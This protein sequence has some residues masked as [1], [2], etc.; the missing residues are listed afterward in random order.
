MES[1]VAGELKYIIRADIDDFNEGLAKASKALDRM[2]QHMEESAAEGGSSLSKG[3]AQ[4]TDA[5]TNSIAKFVSNSTAQLQDF[6]KSAASVAGNLA[7]TFSGMATGTFTSWATQGIFDTKFL[8][9][10]QIQMQALTHSAEEGSRA[11]AMATNYFKNNP[12]NRFDVTDATKQLIQ[13]G[14]SLDEVPALLEKMGNVSLSTGVAI[15]DLARVYQRAAADGRVGLMDIEMLADRGV[16]IWDAFSKAV[17][18]S[19]S[20]IREE[21]AK[22]GIAVEDF[23]KAFEYLVDPAAMEANEKTFSR[24]LDRMKGRLSNLKAALAGYSMDPTKGLIID[25][26]GLYRAVTRMMKVFSDTMSGDVGT[27]L[28][29]SLTRL[30]SK[31]SPYLD[32]F[33]DKIPMLLEKVGNAIDF[34]ADHTE[35]LLPILAGALALFGNLASGIPGLD[36]V[37]GPFGQSIGTMGKVFGKLNPL[38]K[39]FVAILGAGAFK[40]IQDGSLNG[41]FKSISDSLGK[42]A[43]A[44]APVIGRIAEL[45]ANIGEATLVPTINALAKV[46]EIFAN[47]VSAIP[48]PALTALIT[49]I[50]GLVVAKKAVGPVKEFGEAFSRTMKYFQEG[51]NTIR[52]AINS[53]KGLTGI[54]KKA[55]DAASTTTKSLQTASVELTK[56][57]KLMNTIRSGILNLILLAGAI[58]A[59]A[60]AIWVVNKLLPDDMGALVGKLT[61]VGIVAAAMTGIGYA[62]GK[63]KVDWKSILILAGYAADIAVLAAAL[64]AVDK[65]VPND[66]GNLAAK[67]GIMAGVIIAMGVISGVL[68]M[69]AEIE[70]WG[71]AVVIGFAAD[72]ALLALSLLVVDRAVTN[73]FGNLAAKLGIMAGVI[74][75][76]GVI[77]SLLGIFAGLSLA[78]SV[79]VIAFAADLALL[80]LALKTVNN[81]IS[82]DYE[83]LKKKLN[84][85]AEAVQGMAGV[86]A[87]LGI[88]IATGIGAIILGG[89]IATILGLA[90]AMADIADSIKIINSKVP[91]N[92]QSVKDK[93]SSMSEI[94]KVMA[95][96]AAG[97]FW[98][99]LNGS[100]NVGQI[101]SIAQ[102]YITIADALNKIQSISLNAETIRQKVQLIKECIAIVSDT[103][104]DSLGLAIDQMLK[105]FINT[106]NIDNISKVIGTYKDIAE[107]LNQIQSIKLSEETIRRKVGIVQKTVMALSNS[108]EGS[109]GLAIDHACKQFLDTV[110]TDNVAAVI[111]TYKDIADTLNQ[112]Q[113]VELNE[114]EIDDKIRQISEIVKLISNTEEADSLWTMLDQAARTATERNV[115][116]NAGA[117]LKVYS[118]ICDAVNNIRKTLPADTTTLQ[119]IENKIANIRHFIW[120]ASQINEGVGDI[121]NK[122]KIAENV[123]NILNNIKDIAS[124]ITSI[125]DLGD[126]NYEGI[127][128]RIRNI[129]YIAGQINESAGNENQAAI[130]ERTATILTKFKEIATIV[131][132]IPQLADG[133]EDR[134]RTIQNLIYIAGLINEESNTEDKLAIVDRAVQMISKYK[135]IVDV[136]AQIGN[137][138]EDIESKIDTIAKIAN[139]VGRSI[140]DFDDIESRAEGLS[141][142]VTAINKYAEIAN[143]LQNFPDK[144]PDDIEDRIN[145]IKNIVSNIGA[146]MRIAGEVYGTD[147]VLESFGNVTTIVGE[148]VKLGSTINSIPKLAEDTETKITLV[149]NAINNIVSLNLSSLT[150]EKVAGMQF[151]SQIAN[152]M[153]T[154]GNAVNAIPALTEGKDTQIMTYKNI[155][156]NL[157]NGIIPVYD[158]EDKLTTVNKSVEILRAL[159]LFSQVAGQVQ[160]VDQGVFS[161]IAA[162]C[163]TINQS[164]AQLVA[165]LGQQIPNFITIGQQMAQGLGDGW[166][167]VGVDDTIRNE[168]QSVI[169][170]L[171]GKVEEFR[172]LGTNFGNALKDGLANVDLKGT[173]TTQGQ[174]VGLGFA[175]GINSTVFRINAA[176]GNISSAAI[177]TLKNLLGIA[178]PSKVFR[179]LG[180][181]TGEGFAEGLESQIKYIQN[182]ADQISEA[183]NNPFDTNLGALNSNIAA[184]GRNFNNSATN[185]TINQNNIINN[186]ADYS[187][188]M[189]DLKWALFTA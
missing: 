33:T 181:Y 108:D 2:A 23:K 127:I 119:D 152:E 113:G 74:V 151:A 159:V 53:F 99:N 64:W 37:L 83:P 107:T 164:I 86:A 155:M 52:G 133:V 43:K 129:I 126:K 89:G 62:V 80:A 160:S 171:N 34:V 58:A 172:N 184:G 93:I 170:E 188:M 153:I 178:S 161:T 22:G 98:Q 55:S 97:N 95:E 136:T 182:A 9:D 168:I 92:T 125:P 10:T 31:I 81:N 134:V 183:I 96:N 175:A 13:F 27:R 109:I 163:Q 78:G 26:N 73:D 140:Q 180:E 69:F 50:A 158:I 167:G 156:Q 114:K 41:T 51:G 132:E 65:L 115:T 3:V 16:P 75:A 104:S 61:T 7:M 148:F 103:E 48:E 35:T 67:L 54:G 71:I 121:E 72:L 42:L 47:V 150:E 44:L 76:M 139:K 70:G 135:E 112:I 173:A 68:G 157:I 138:P 79:A 116:E 30:A 146:S 63:L 147:E 29:D 45:A 144:L 165:D 117:I 19:A 186:G 57:Q 102:S 149:K 176:M 179:Q 77:T 25:E 49:A 166:T 4:G 141:A 185:T 5:A 24:Q 88:V 91:T 66:F 17:G 100:M 162:I 32:K 154:F 40:A 189:N 122:A 60:G 87:T 145:R 101:A 169:N 15:N 82:S 56:G 120:V 11:M 59:L 106:I 130:V 8:E 6:A 131:N 177:S 28:M 14:A 85:M 118:E 111:R 123:K 90:Q 124:T 187:A 143:V 38:M 137:L 94:M 39:V 12:F 142:V 46:L 84:N 36:R 105:N 110:N 20:Q 21:T 174:N 128:S 1:D 18:K